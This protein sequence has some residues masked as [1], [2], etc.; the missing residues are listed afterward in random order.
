MYSILYVDD[1]E[2]LLKLNKIFLEKSGNFTVEVVSSGPAALERIRACRYDA[3][4]SD[5]QMPEMDGIELLKEVRRQFGRIPFILFT[6]KGREEIVIE[7]LNNGADFYIQKGTDVKGMIAELKH[8]LC[9]AIDRRRTENALQKS[10][11]QLMD[12]INF[13]PD[14]TFVIDVQGN[15]IAWNRAIETMTGINQADILGKG[16]FEYSIP[17]FGERKP[18]LI[19]AVVRGPYLEEMPYPDL[20]NEDNKIT[21]DIYSSHLYGGRGAHLLVSAGP[22]YDPDGNIVGAI[23]TLRD[24]TDIHKTKRDLDITREK[25][26]GLTSLFPFAVIEMN[27]SYN[28]TY[29][30]RL[31][32]DFFR[33]TLNDISGTISILDYIAPQDRDRLLRDIQE[34]LQ[35]K[36]SSTGSEYLLRRKDGSVFP[37]RVYG[38]RRVDPGTG[39]PAGFRGI[40]IDITQEKQEALA[41]N[42]TQGRL[43]LALEAGHIG[44]WDVDIQKMQIHDL[45]QWIDDML[46]YNLNQQILTV[47]ACLAFIHPL[48]MPGILL[49]FRNY[50]KGKTSLFECK[51]RAKHQ[52]GTWVDVALRGQVIEQDTNG[53]PLRITGIVHAVNTPSE[54][55]LVMEQFS[56][57]EEIPATRSTNS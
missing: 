7:A 3:I 6:G 43:K 37:A 14:A 49:A 22:L 18:I 50:T 2:V 16:D 25:N 15:V 38:E 48:D 39:K 53:D 40:I 28:I 5:Y 56:Q 35:G 34:A 23:E 36:R 29:A 1:D 32:F 46:G 10:E 17:F 12:I 42:E 13:L 41:L 24:I 31:A 9:T 19:D 4:L 54:R 52:K 45:N 47:N 57:I 55:F 21:T 51:F 20:K 33:V 26:Q 30:N 11:R 8:K 27:L 44:I